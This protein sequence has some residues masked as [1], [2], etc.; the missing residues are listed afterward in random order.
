MGNA[1]HS[2]DIGNRSFHGPNPDLSQ[3]ALLSYCF[4]ALAKEPN[5]DGKVTSN[6]ITIGIDFSDKTGR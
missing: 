4:K 3:L 2:D 5:K 6:A 1:N